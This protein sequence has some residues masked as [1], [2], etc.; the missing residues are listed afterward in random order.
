MYG[1]SP[2]LEDHDARS[3]LAAPGEVGKTL[4]ALPVLAAHR[5]I[6]ALLCAVL[7]VD[8][9]DLTMGGAV[10]AGLLRAGWT[11][12]SLNSMFFSAAGLGAALGV[13]VAGNLADRLGRVRVLQICLALMSIG[14]LL[15]AVAPTMAFL[16]AARVLAAVGM[17]GLPTIGYVYLNEVLPARVRGAWISGAG[18]V[19]AGSSSAASLMALYLLPM[20]GW[21]IMFL[22]PAVAGILSIAAL[23]VIPESPRWLAVKGQAD[24][25]AKALAR[26]AGSGGGFAEAKSGTPSPPI[27]SPQAVGQGV[28]ALFRAQFARPLSLAIGLAVA[29]N[30]TSNSAI[31]WLPTLLLAD[32]TIERGLGDNLVIMLGAPLGSVIG[33]FIV[34]RVSRRGLIAGSALL[35]TALAAACGYAGRDLGLIPLAFVLMAL[36][37]LICTIVLGVY[38]SELFP[39]VLRARGS[40]MALTASRLSLIAAPFVMATLLDAF[41]RVGIMLSLTACLLVTAL[42][43]IV[44]GEETSRRPLAE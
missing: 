8:F 9:Y 38:L 21:R 22:M 24:A 41:G 11:T 23:T 25:A 12:I 1:H 29:V 37:N 13:F 2:P 19:V 34:G 33:Y 42:L 5:R 18:L 28:G 14:T 35:A 31:A 40:A 6:F 20:G 30:V 44:L 15:C 39:T 7:F 36:I 16:I 32:G 10:A 3:G 17:G 4:D 27:A 43:V 26:I